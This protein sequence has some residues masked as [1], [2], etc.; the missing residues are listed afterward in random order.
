VQIMVNKW[1]YYVKI[2][3]AISSSLVMLPRL[4]IFAIGGYDNRVFVN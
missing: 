1:T 2:K 3:I 4:D